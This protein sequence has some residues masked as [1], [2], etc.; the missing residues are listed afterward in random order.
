MELFLYWLLRAS[1]L[2]ALFY[3]LYKFFFSNNTFHNVN[4]FSLI[5]ML[6]MIPALPLFRFNL[7]PEKN[8][9]PVTDTF[10]ADFSSFPVMESMDMQPRAEIPWAQILTVL[11]A[12]GFLFTMTRY[13][14]G[15]GRIVAI[16]RKSKK[17]TLDD[18]AVLCVTDKNISPFSWMRY[19]VLS[20]K[21][22]SVDNQAV[23]RHEKAH[24]RLRHSFDMIFFDVFT[25]IFWFNPFS[26]LLRREIQSVHEYQA[27]EQVLNQGI[28][29][30]QYQLLLIRKSVG[31]YKFALANNFRRRDLH[32]RIIMMKKNKTNRRMKWNYAMA[33]P[34]LF[35][36]MVALSLPKMNAK[37]AAKENLPAEPAGNK[38]TV[39]GQ[40]MDYV[41]DDSLKVAVPGLAQD[42]QG[43]IIVRPVDS[44]QGDVKK[45]T[46]RTTG[47]KRPLI[48][49]DVTI[50]SEEELQELNPDNIESI[51]ILKDKSSVDI[52]GDK[53]K[54]GVV[55]ITTKNSPKNAITIVGAGLTDSLRDDVKGLVI[56][57]KIIQNLGFSNENR[58]LIILDGEK[59]S[60]DFDLNL[61]DTHDIESI[62][63]LKDK[64]ATEIYGDEGKN[65][66]IIITKKVPVQ[67]P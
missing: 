21:E 65:G 18:H 42:K 32:K 26:W 15:L 17:Q 9:K 11:F 63:V 37:V 67:N 13:L 14:I 19:I 60:K 5:C 50:I 57:T 28:D 16:I 2:M 36:A 10:L 58:P 41:S 53:G 49:V 39:S 61:I 29:S 56:E 62:S 55:L 46:L 34:V 33:F 3:G 59:M 7:I 24:I 52:Y 30:K 40:M 8:L 66:V 45:V 27:D 43:V 4:R 35:L 25:C 6:L 31:E 22:L 23:I 12:V 38:I 20:S 48:I 47:D 1:V 51:S 64:S 54:D 44:L